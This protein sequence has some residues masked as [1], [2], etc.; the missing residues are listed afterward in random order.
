MINEA[1]E[2]GSPTEANPSA[3]AAATPA[4][5]DSPTAASE[6]TGAPADTGSPT[7]AS[8]SASTSPVDEDSAAPVLERSTPFAI[9]LV[10]VIGALTSGVF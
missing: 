9:A 8:E 7:E 3:T 6:S 1:A 5:T 10:A 2:T 4:N